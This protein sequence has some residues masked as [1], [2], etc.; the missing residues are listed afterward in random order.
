M[1]SSFTDVM[2]ATLLITIVGRLKQYT[3]VQALST[4]H[5][6]CIEA[7]YLQWFI[8]L[9]PSSPTEQA[10]SAV[11]SDGWKPLTTTILSENT[12]N[13][14][15]GDFLPSRVQEITQRKFF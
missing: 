11:S 9:A 15:Y 4:R 1:T 12:G 6:V 8:L 13:D 2:L 5:L 3:A 7:G 14:G 10:S